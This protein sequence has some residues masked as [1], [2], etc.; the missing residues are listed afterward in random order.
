MKQELISPSR[1]ICLAGAAT[2]CSSKA[3]RENNG[4]GPS[5]VTGHNGRAQKQHRNDKEG[6]QKASGFI[7]A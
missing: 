6:R 1:A 2:G 4:Y 3:T 7:G 5:T